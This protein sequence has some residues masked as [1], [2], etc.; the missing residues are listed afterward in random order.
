LLCVLILRY[1]LANIH[2]CFA[3]GTALGASLTKSSAYVL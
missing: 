3:F 2:G 1:I